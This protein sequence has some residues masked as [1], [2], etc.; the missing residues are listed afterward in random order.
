MA[1]LTALTLAITALLP[2]LTKALPSSLAAIIIVTILNLCCASRRQDG[3]R[4]GIGAWGVPH[5]HLPVVPLTMETLRAS[6]VLIRG[7]GLTEL[8]LTQTLIDEMTDTNRRIIGNVFVKASA[9]S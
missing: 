4:P 1:G 3:K 2:E 7:V 5:F 9:T 6:D 8:L